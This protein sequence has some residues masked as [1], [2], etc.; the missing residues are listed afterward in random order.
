LQTKTRAGEFKGGRKYFYIEMPCLKCI[1]KMK[2]WGEEKFRRFLKLFRISRGLEQYEL[3][4][5]RL[6]RRLLM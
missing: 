2:L 5:S 4:G 1:S 3:A 6:A